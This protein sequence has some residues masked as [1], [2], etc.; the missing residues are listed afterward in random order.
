MSYITLSF[1]FNVCEDIA[2]K[3]FS[4]A[5]LFKIATHRLLR[6]TQEMSYLP[7]TDIGWKNE[8]REIIYKIIPNRRYTDGVIVLVRSIYESCRELSID[9]KSV[10]LN[11]W[12]MFQQ[13]EKEYPCRCF[14]LKKSEYFT[15]HITT[16]D[17]FGKTHRV[18]IKPTV[19]KTYKVLLEKNS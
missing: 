17:Y 2:C 15:F 16:I 6:I 14:T 11:N 7:S 8:F 13:V 3:L 12:L 9:F 4:T 10:E 5:W 1:P 19:S 18:I